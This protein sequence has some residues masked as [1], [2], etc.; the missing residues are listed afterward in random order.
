MHSLSTLVLLCGLL[1]AQ[2]P[3]GPSG[4]DWPGWR[5]PNRDAVSRETGLLQQWTA[6]GPPVAWKAGGLGAGFSS[7][8]ISGDHIYT[9]GD[10]GEDQYL[11]ALNRADGKEL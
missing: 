7:L 10:R 9:M 5:G 11:I 3:S 1:A 2:V 8:A 6:S 4:N